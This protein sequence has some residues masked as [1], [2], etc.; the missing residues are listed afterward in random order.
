MPRKVRTLLLALVVIFVLAMM[1]VLFWFVGRTPPASPLPNPNGYDDFLNAAALLTGDVGNASTLHHDGL[2]ALVSTN[3]EPLRLLRL[4]LTRGCS[5]PTDF[6][7]TNVAGLLGDLANLTQVR[8]Q[9]GLN[10][11]FQ[12]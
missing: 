9:E 12:G 8:Q 2:R 6:A 3:A 5:V 11:F 7:M 1:T 4:G 10:R